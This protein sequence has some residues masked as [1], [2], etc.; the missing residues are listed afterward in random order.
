MNVQS[1]F[2][3]FTCQIA[4]SKLR[5]AISDMLTNLTNKQLC[6]VCF[7]CPKSKPSVTFNIVHVQWGNVP[8]STYPCRHSAVLDIRRLYKH[9]KLVYRRF[10][11]IFGLGSF[12]RNFGLCT[13]SF[14]TTI[15]YQFVWCM[16][17]VQTLK[18]C[19]SHQKPYHVD[20]TLGRSHASDSSGNITQ[21]FRPT[22]KRYLLSR[23]KAAGYM[24]QHAMMA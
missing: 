9:E 22:L 4:C 12:Y 20:C 15:L 14:L 23:W 18:S 24:N 16:D 17:L 1:L 13:L 3:I 10:F 8:Y 19:D 5:V 6:T 2:C 11:R 21:C 7:A